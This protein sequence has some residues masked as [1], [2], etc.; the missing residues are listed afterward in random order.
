MRAF[1]SALFALTAVLAVS[2]KNVVVTVG[3]NTTDNATMVFDPAQVS[4]K[5][6]DIVVFNFTIGNHTV[7]Q[8]TFASPC[9]P[10]HDTNITIN[11]FDSGFRDTVNGTAI[12]IL[13]VPITPDL[14]NETIWFYDFNTCAEGGVGGINIDDN[15]TETLDGFVRNAIRLNGTGGDDSSSSTFSSGPTGSS[16]SYSSVPSPTG[17]G[18]SSGASP[19]RQLALG[20]MAVVPVVLAALAL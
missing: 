12:T 2:A 10:A 1:T 11:G 9:T 14:V 8:S 4:A 7:T 18:S 15:S 13:S 20:V 17:A 5:L 6:N 19:E 16:S 3:K